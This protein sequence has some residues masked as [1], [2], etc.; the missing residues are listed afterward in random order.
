MCVCPCMWY[1]FYSYPCTSS[2]YFPYHGR[3]SKEKNV[4]GIHVLGVKYL[5]VVCLSLCMFVIHTSQQT[6]RRFRWHFIYVGSHDKWTPLQNFIKI[7]ADNK[8]HLIRLH[9]W[10]RYLAHRHAPN[11]QFSITNAQYLLF[12][13]YF[14][15]GY[16]KREDQL[17]NQYVTQSSSEKIFWLSKCFL[18]WNEK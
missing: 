4:N 15:N 3:S 11:A 16:L 12:Y 10:W 8:F 7:R 13:L 9:G 2:F 5:D 1:R 6:Y 17:K 14:L 18:T